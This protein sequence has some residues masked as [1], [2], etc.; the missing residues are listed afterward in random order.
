MWGEV[1]LVDPEIDINMKLYMYRN[2][3]F[4]LSWCMNHVHINLNYV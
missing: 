3:T 4:T 1:Y 2:S